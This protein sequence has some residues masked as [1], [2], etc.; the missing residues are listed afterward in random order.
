MDKII[1]ITVEGGVVQS[2]EGI[3][4]GVTVRVLDFDTD[5][6]D[7]DSLTALPNGEK[8]SVSE[9]QARAETS[10]PEDTT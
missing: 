7:D 6:A 5:G 8:A 10:G 3:P 2:V 4:R 9:W 1:T